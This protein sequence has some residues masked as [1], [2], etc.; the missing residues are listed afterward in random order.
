MKNTAAYKNSG[1]FLRKTACN[2]VLLAALVVTTARSDAQ[3][4]PVWNLEDLK[5]AMDTASGPTIINFWATFCKPCIAELPHFQDAAT[6]YRAQGLRLVLVSLDL[7]ESYPKAVQHFVARRKLTAPVV[8][9]DEANADLFVPA[10]DS[11]WSGAIPAS[12]FLNR[13]KGY[14]QFYE[15]E[16]SKTKLDAAIR[17][18]FE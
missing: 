13:G 16:L 1:V 11:S 3:A 12:L 7:K 14:R 5:T 4:I 18:L 15:E 9:L 10:V 2:L 8:F 17:K 6:R